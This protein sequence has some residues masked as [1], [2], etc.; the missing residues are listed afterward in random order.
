MF[1]P[2]MKMLFSTEAALSPNLAEGSGAVSLQ[3]PAMSSNTSVEFREMNPPEY[4]APPVTRSTC[5]IMIHYLLI[6][7]EINLTLSPSSVR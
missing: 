5:K 4:C 6:F 3:V 1:S 7:N 2:N